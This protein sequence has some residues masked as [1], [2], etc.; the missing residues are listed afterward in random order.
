M[1]LHQEK[2]AVELD[3]QLSQLYERQCQ[4]LSQA[5]ERLKSLKGDEDY[6]TDSSEAEETKQSIALWKMKKETTQKTLLEHSTVSK[7]AAASAPPAAVAPRSLRKKIAAQ[8]TKQNTIEIN[9]SSSESS[10]DESSSSDEGAMLNKPV[11]KTSSEKENCDNKE[12]VSPE[13]KRSRV[14][15]RKNDESDIDTDSD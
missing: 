10:S 14:G 7:P 5:R 12:S 2:H 9:E 15:N 4:S 3:E 11:F 6:D 8:F 1:C 13:K